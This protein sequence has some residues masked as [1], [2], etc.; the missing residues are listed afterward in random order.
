MRPPSPRTN[1]RTG[2]ISPPPSSSP[3]PTFPLQGKH[4]GHPHLPDSQGMNLLSLLSKVIPPFSIS[5]NLIL[6][7]CL[8]SASFLLI[9]LV[10]RPPR[11]WGTL[12]VHQILFFLK[13]FFCLDY[14][15][16][17]LRSDC[18]YLRFSGLVP[19]VSVFTISS[20]PI[21]PDWIV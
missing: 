4:L 2:S 21:T 7:P 9:I 18:P 6:R 3:P 10:R 12:E 5:F 20:Y 11:V 14:F 15:F 13:H 19:S 17:C 8:F 1:Y 16:F